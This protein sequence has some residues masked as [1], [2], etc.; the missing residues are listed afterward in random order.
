MKQ[1][2]CYGCIPTNLAAVLH[3]GQI[4]EFDDPFDG[5]RKDVDEST[6][7]E[8]YY[9]YTICFASLEKAGLF[10]ILQF[11]KCKMETQSARSFD[12]WWKMVYEHIR[13]GSYV[14]LS[15]FIPSVG[16]HTVTAYEIDTDVLN[17]YNPA[18]GKGSWTRAELERMWLASLLEEPDRERHRLNHDILVVTVPTR[19]VSATVTEEKAPSSS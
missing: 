3:S 16:I 5:R 1:Q 4:K 13:E 8:L 12:E 2:L 19:N 18:E 15:Y 11:R 14:L 7:I 17:V 9:K 6:I 10:S